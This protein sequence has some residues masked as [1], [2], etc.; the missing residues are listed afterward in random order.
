MKSR[1]RR[2]ARAIQ[3][4]GV[5]A[6]LLLIILVLIGCVS[7]FGQDG[8]LNVD[9]RIVGMLNLD[10]P[11]TEEGD[12][13]QIGILVENHGAKDARD[14]PVYFYEDGVYFEKET[15][16]IMA[17]DTVYVETFWTADSGDSYISVTVDPSG[18]FEEDKGDNVTGLWMTVR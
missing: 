16:D 3:L 13:V 12:Y 15:V 7:S 14:V 6:V 17:G 8:S 1:R 5:K 10:P 18:D 11:L 9:L 2:T 4:S